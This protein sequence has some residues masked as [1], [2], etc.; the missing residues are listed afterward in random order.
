M[1]S[2]ISPIF[3]ELC[4]SAGADKQA[5]AA[6]TTAATNINKGVTGVV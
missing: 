3:P 4:A 2:P 1:L 6:R 5:I